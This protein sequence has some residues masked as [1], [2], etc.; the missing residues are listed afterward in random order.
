MRKL[1]MMLAVVA[2]MAAATAEAAEEAKISLP[3]EVVMTNDPA[4]RA[5]FVV[6]MFFASCF[7]NFFTPERIPEWAD[8]YMNLLVPEDAAQFLKSVGAK[9]GRVWYAAIPASRKP[10][11]AELVPGGE[12]ALVSEP[13]KCHIV[14]LGADE[15]A[16]HAAIEKFSKDAKANMKGREIAYTYRAKGEAPRGGK[17]VVNNTSFVT[18]RQPKN[19]FV[20]TVFGTSAPG[21]LQEVTSMIT[22]FSNAKLPEKPAKK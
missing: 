4:Q 6:N 3:P 1:F 12:F 5:Q 11:S 18:I 17:P 22:V 14:G 15:V 8:T 9:E 2:A 21:K 13:G 16:F 20:M 7:V 10:V 19:G